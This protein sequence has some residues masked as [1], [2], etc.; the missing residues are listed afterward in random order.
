MK[1]AELLTYLIEREFEDV[2]R[3]VQA[4]VGHQSVLALALTTA[5]VRKQLD[6][7]EIEHLRGLA[8]E[9]A[10]MLFGPVPKMPYDFR[11]T[12]SPTDS[13]LWALADALVRA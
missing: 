4:Q 3:Y 2:D 11:S 5:V 13:R 1:P 6:A 10:T 7:T 12:T 9:A 8:S